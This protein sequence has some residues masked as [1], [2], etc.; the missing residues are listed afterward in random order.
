M[1]VVAVYITRTLAPRE[2][3]QTQIR[4]SIV[5]SKQL[6]ICLSKFDPL[7]E[8]LVFSSQLS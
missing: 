5:T 6:Q 7:I 3:R 1:N 2:G 8:L 4:A